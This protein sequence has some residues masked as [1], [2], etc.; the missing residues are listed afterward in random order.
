MS[1]GCESIWVLSKK[2]RQNLPWLWRVVHDEVGSVTVLSVFV[3]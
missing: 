3:L 2:V 1:D